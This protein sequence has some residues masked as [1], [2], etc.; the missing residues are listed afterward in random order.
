MFDEQELAA[1]GCVFQE[2]LGWE[3][4]GW[5]HSTE[6]PVKQYDWYQC[7]DNKADPD[8]RYI[9]LL[10][11]E[12]TFECSPHEEQVSELFRRFSDIILTNNNKIIYYYPM[13]YLP[14]SQIKKEC[15][16]CRNDVVGYDMS[17]FG[18]IH[19]KPKAC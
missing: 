17:Y 7:Y 19:R 10:K 6:A 11:E 2:R 14:L 12:Y 4:P 16:A 15:L 8:Q 9:D 1:S 3:R 13:Y 5:F 18:N